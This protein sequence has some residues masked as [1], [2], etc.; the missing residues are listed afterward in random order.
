MGHVHPGVQVHQH[1]PGAVKKG[2]VRPQGQVCLVRLDLRSADIQGGMLV[3]GHRGL[4]ADHPAVGQQGVEGAPGDLGG[5]DVGDGVERA[6]VPDKCD[7]S[8]LQRLDLQW[9]EGGLK[10]EGQDHPRGIQGPV[11][12]GGRGH[13]DVSLPVVEH[14]PALHVQ[15]VGE[16]TGCKGGGCQHGEK[17]RAHKDSW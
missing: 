8:S 17:Y 12:Q 5:V 10:P 7:P 1:H 2:A 14:H 15:L 11:H 3:Q 4:H 13:G 9:G 16:A 6:S